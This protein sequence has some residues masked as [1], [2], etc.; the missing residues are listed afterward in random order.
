[1]KRYLPMLVLLAAELSAGPAHAAISRESCGTGKDLVV[2]AL[3]RLRA[4]STQDQLYEA[5]QLL[6]RSAAECSELGDAWYYRSLVEEQLGHKD[7]AAFAL[8]RA[9][10]FPSD[11]MKD[12]LNPFVLAAP[13]QQA[14]P[15][16]TVRDKWALI[17]GISNFADKNIPGLNY[18]TADAKSFR[19]T[20]EDPKYGKFPAD[21]VHILT[22]SE[23]TT[24]N[25]KMELNWLARNAAPEDVAVVYIASHGSPRD[26]DTAGA[27]YIITHDTEIGPDD[28]P[29]KLF[30]TALPMVELSNTVATRVRARRTAVFID[31]CYSGGAAVGAKA[32][33]PGIGNAGVSKETLAHISQGD[34]R[35]IL[36]AS[37]DQEE[38]LESDQLQHGYFTYYLVEA[39]H[40]LGGQAT[41][42]QVYDYVR[43]HV[44]D[45]VATDKKVYHSHQTPVM[46]RSSAS[47]DFAF[48]ASEAPAAHTAAAPQSSS[49][50]Q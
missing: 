14:T 22:D 44:S 2:Q 1:M 4:D 46:S 35:V 33:A 37:T 3:E 24:R 6:K 39:L 47:T 11:A 5:N 41:M 50:G 13:P 45:R 26:M 9:R 40:T 21:H 7:V 25:I 30:A 38:S 48:L 36:A 17:I 16:A 42:S 31:T 15:L 29:D 8:G 27:N 23:A 49:K 32:M 20:I 28:D 43:T 19:D 10:L 18:T 12:G 34:G